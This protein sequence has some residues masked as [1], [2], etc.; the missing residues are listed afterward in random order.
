VDWIPRDPLW[1]WL[2][3]ALALGLLCLAGAAL[4]RAIYTVRQYGLSAY[5]RSVI[6]IDPENF[7]VFA[8]L[9]LLAI[10]VM[11]MYLRGGG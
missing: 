4:G 10:G 5:L 6:R 3:G 1:K 7:R 9:G 2:F 8:V 11:L